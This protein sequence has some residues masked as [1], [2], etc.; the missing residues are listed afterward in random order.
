MSNKKKIVRKKHNL[1][2]DM[3]TPSHFLGSGTD[4]SV[5]SIGMELEERYPEA[6]N[7]SDEVFEYYYNKVEQELQDEEAREK[8]WLMK[9]RAKREHESLTNREKEAVA[10]FA[11]DLISC[12]SSLWFAVNGMKHPIGPQFD[13]KRIDK[14][15]RLYALY[16]DG[17][18]LKPFQVPEDLFHTIDETKSEKTLSQET[19]ELQAKDNYDSS[20][21]PSK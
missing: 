12:F 7:A 2:P 21:N 10:P 8:E 4:W 15:E 6:L 20:E 13:I 5:L 11:H 17:K 1:S 16:M 19:E 18:P 3:F 14:D 9:M